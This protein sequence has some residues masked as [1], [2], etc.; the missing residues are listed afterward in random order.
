MQFKNIYIMLATLVVV[1][2]AVTSLRAYRLWRKVFDDLEDYEDY[3]EEAP[4]TVLDFESLL[5]STPTLFFCRN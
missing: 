1:H 5:V 3:E 4:E 2:D